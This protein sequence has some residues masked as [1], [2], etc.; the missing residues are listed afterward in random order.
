MLLAA[1]A[2]THPVA[3][4]RRWLIGALVCSAAGDFL[5]AMPWWE[6]SFVLG[7]AAFLVAHCA[8]WP[9]CCR[10]ASHRRRGSAA[11]AVVVAACVAL[12]I[13]FWPS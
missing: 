7:L 5:L 8:S 6:P 12:L 11:A 10:C 1:A 4:E 3:R 9:R 2:L 13:W